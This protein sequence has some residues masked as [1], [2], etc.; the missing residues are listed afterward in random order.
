MRTQ[1]RKKYIYSEIIKIKEEQN[2]RNN[3]KIIINY[4]AVNS[5]WQG[6]GAWD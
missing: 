6:E 1:G 2:N 3:R 5:H 4:C